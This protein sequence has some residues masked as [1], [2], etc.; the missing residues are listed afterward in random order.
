MFLLVEAP[1]N[2]IENS[3]GMTLCSCNTVLMMMDKHSI[4]WL[5]VAPTTPGL[6]MTCDLVSPWTN[7]LHTFIGTVLALSKILL[8]PSLSA[9]AKCGNTNSWPL[10]Q[11]IA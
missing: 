6:K 11:S 9:A 1:S 5:A 2:C 4:V 7:P 3:G 10:P 8:G